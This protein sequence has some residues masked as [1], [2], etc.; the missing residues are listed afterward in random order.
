MYLREFQCIQEVRVIVDD[1]H[2]S[3]QMLLKINDSLNARMT[4]EC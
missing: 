1:K 2:S 4:Q 3:F